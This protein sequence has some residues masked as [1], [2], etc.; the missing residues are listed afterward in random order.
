MI[1]IDGSNTG[2]VKGD[3]PTFKKVSKEEALFLYRK[4]VLARQAEEKIREE[5]FKDAMKTPVHLGIGGEAIPVGVCHCLP[6]TAKTF[7]SYR[8][9]T[10][11]LTVTGDTDSFFGEL[12]GKVTGA[13]KGKAGSMHLMAPERG[14]M[15]TSAVVG[16]TVSVAVGAALANAYNQSQN[17]VAVFFG[18]GTVEEGAFWESLNFACLHHLRILFVCED[19][20]LAIHTPI[21][22]RRGFN[23][24][25]KTVG[26][27]DCYVDEGDGA[28]IFDVIWKTRRVLEQIA[29]SPKPAFLRFPYF[30][31]LEHVGP[32]EDFDAGYRA[33]PAR[34]EL[35]KFD[36][37][38]R[39][40]KELQS[41]GWAT[42]ELS[43]IKK[44][45]EAQINR[46]VAVAQKAPFPSPS[47]LWEDVFA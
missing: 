41:C 30:R 40:E 1:T 6:L 27:F 46:S 21:F 38:K 9:H 42:G 8:N 36:P 19:N 37:L 23:S 47:D 3:C 10:L 26:T 17:I 33:R 24:L 5:Y 4:L 44:A 45:V 35:E 2:Q 22:A 20:D 12:Y 11:F 32:G 16:T 39:F 14:L 29:A 13:G 15:A 28:D 34:E 31:F 43:G 18:D 7:G 25:T